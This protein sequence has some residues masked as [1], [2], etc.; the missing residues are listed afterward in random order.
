MVTSTADKEFVDPAER[1]ARGRAARR[2]VPR[3]S[4]ADWS[5]PSDRPDPATVLAVQAE[6]RVP[7]LIPLRHERMLASPFAF[8][9]G[10]AAIMAGDLA[11]TPDSGIE[12]QCCGDAHLANFGGFESPERS[13]MF[14]INDFDETLP[15]PWE[16]DVKRLAT[17]F[18]IASQDRGFSDR[19]AVRAT[20]AA[21]RSYRVAMREFALQRDLEVW[22]ARLDVQGIL[23][24]W[25]KT[26][27][28]SDLKR[29]E[30]TTAKGTTKNSLK[31]LT[32]LTEVVDG[33][34]QIRSDPPILVRM[35]DLVPAEHADRM[36]EHM[37]DSMR[38]Y[39]RTLPRDRNRL[40]E[41]Y[42]IVDVA[43]KVVGVGSV[44][45]RCWIALMLG[46]DDSDP[47]FLQIKE[48]QASVLEPYAGTSEYT[49]PGQR[50]V[51]GQR[52]MQAASDIFLGWDEV[53]GI[54]GVV[55]PIYVRQLWDGKT[56]ADLAGMPSTLFETYAQLCGWTLARAHARSGDR[57]AIGAYLGS[58]GSFD[59]AIVEFAFKYADQNERDY[60]AASVAVRDGRLAINEPITR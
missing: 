47:L 42:R 22:Y 6:T 28:A 25:R 7:E 11:H 4:H 41:R 40:F 35:H 49:H 26:V 3:S 18:V 15:A 56:S 17:S 1:A 39:S 13:L 33:R 48:A 20:T 2:T 58:G 60:E 38:S 5:A 8:Y 21:A 23:D 9:R 19:V 14:D 31:A 50:V 36:T 43:R 57:V 51:E 59:R 32:K 10:T 53:D 29:F 30:R 16:W 45:T 55:R 34:R 12:V 37:C 44:G 27:S 54:D 46:R 52:L 24:R